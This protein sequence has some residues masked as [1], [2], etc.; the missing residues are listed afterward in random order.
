M[1]R[2]SGYYKL[3]QTT[4]LTLDSTICGRLF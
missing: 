3:W 2:T 4:D 1:R